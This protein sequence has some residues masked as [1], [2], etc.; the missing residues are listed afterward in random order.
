MRL[1]MKIPASALEEV[2]QVQAKAAK[3]WEQWQITL[4]HSSYISGLARC[5][6]DPSNDVTHWLL[7]SKEL[8]RSGTGLPSRSHL[9]EG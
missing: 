6:D 5:F 2:R 1:P 7:D 4:R 8:R 3:R 9:S